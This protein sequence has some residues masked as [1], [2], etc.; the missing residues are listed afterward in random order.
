MV[1]RASLLAAFVVLLAG[2]AAAGDLGV[3][4]GSWNLSGGDATDVLG[5]RAALGGPVLAGEVAVSSVGDVFDREAPHGGSG[6][7]LVPVDLG[8][9]WMPAG[10][11]PLLP[12]LEAGVTWAH[13]TSGG[14]TYSDGWG[15]QAH[16]GVEIGDRRGLEGFVELGYRDVELDASMEEQ[17]G[18][19]FTWQATLHGPSVAAGV[20]WRW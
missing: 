6:L 17:P 5:V 19:R 15:W 14:R 10:E 9:R 2:T 7:S 11:G 13:V 4:A 20:L 3:L 1:H 18:V 16:V 8:V 12:Y